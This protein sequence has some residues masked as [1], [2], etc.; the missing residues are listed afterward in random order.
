MGQFSVPACATQ[1]SGFSVR[2]TS[3]KWVIPNNWNINGLH[4][5]TQSTKTWSQQTIQRCFKVAFWLIS[6][7]D[8]GQRQI[9]VETTLRISTLIF[10]TSHNVDSALCISTLMWT[11]LD[12]VKTTSPFSTSSFIMLANV[13]TTL[14]KWRFWKRI[15]KIFQNECT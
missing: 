6:R 8:V 11:T 14:R 1:L 15:Q 2:G 7:C 9:N 4:Q 13:E 5:T 12:D 3:S 10:T